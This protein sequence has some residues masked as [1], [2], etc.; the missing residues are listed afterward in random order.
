LVDFTYSNLFDGVVD[1]PDWFDIDAIEI[2]E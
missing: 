1:L 2:G